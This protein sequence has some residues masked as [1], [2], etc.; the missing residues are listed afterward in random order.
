MNSLNDHCITT[1]NSLLRGELSA[2]ETYGQAL[3]TYA[4]TP[5][6]EELRRIRAE[7]VKSAALLSANVREMGGTPGK[8]SGAWGMFAVAVQG[9]ADLFGET[10]A[11]MSLQQ[12]EEMGRN[13]YKDALLDEHVMPDCKRMISEE[14]LP[15]V[16]NHIVVLESL[17]KTV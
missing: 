5:A 3:E 15:P 16:L 12:G 4:G 1:C 6:A 9:A 13:D 10:S 7:H 8:D 11:L 17:K 2:V 14:L